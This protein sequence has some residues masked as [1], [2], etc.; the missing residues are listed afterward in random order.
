V[1]GRDDLRCNA[2]DPVRPFGSA[3]L[4]A[5][6]SHWDAAGPN[7]YYRTVYLGG[8]CALRSLEGDLGFG[9]MTSFLRSY[10]GAHRFGVTTTADFVAAL[11]AAAPPGYDVDAYLKRARIVVP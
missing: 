1:V 11:R 2:A 8:T 9:A 10:A 3:A 5:P 4:T 6:M 7:P